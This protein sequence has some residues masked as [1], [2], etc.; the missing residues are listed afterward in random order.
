M[1]VEKASFNKIII[2]MIIM[3]FSGSFSTIIIKI[4]VSSEIKLVEGDTNPNFNHPWY[5]AYMVFIGELLCLIP[6]YIIKFC[7]KKEN[8]SQET[9]NFMENKEENSYHFMR[10]STNNASSNT[11]TKPDINIFIIIIPTIFDLLSSSL[12]IISLNFLASSTYQMLRGSYIIFIAI[13][14]IHFLKRK[15]FS[16]NW[17]G[18]ALVLIGLIVVGINSIIEANNNDDDESINTTS[19]GLLLIILSQLLQACLFIS[20]EFLMTSYK[21]EPLK[22]AGMEGMWGTIFYSILI[23]CAYYIPCPIQSDEISYYFCSKIGEKYYL[24]NIYNAVHVLTNNTIIL[25]LNI[26]FILVIGLLAT[27]G[28]WITKNV[29]ATARSIVDTVR[30]IIVWLFFTTIHISKKTDEHFKGIQLIGFILLVAGNII[31]NEVIVLPFWGLNKN[32]Q[33]SVKQQIDD[34]TSSTDV[35]DQQ[36]NRIVLSRW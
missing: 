27:V 13:A 36:Q 30:V 31:Y 33:K 17:L 1:D 35:D 29:S 25:L 16:H 10:Q 19:W 32:I 11:N 8:K 24:E 20:E 5:I 6:Y 23:F 7:I 21:C 28:I 15:I 14:S 3:I 34:A 12:L 26:L 2:F 22:L 9:V 18:M 4:I